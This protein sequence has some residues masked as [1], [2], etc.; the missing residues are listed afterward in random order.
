MIRRRRGL[1]DLQQL[2]NLRVP[3]AVVSGP[4]SAPLSPVL[5]VAPG[6]YLSH[7]QLSAGQRQRCWEEGKQVPG[8]AKRPMCSGT[9]PQRPSVTASPCFF[10]L[11]AKGQPKQQN[12]TINQKRDWS[13]SV[14]HKKT[15]EAGGK[16][17]LCVSLNEQVCDALASFETR[18]ATQQKNA[19]VYESAYLCWKSGQGLCGL[20]K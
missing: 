14:C 5:P 19:E 6:S 3:R 20:A 8:S 12:R 1:T 10:S 15:P 16:T 13:V 17:Q 2:A 11:F 7:L 4:D 18:S 9:D